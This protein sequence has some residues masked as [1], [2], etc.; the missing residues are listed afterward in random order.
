[1]AAVDEVASELG[2]KSLCAAL[3]VS[4]ASWYR[5]KTPPKMRELQPRPRPARALSEREKDR[6]AD[7]LHEPRFVDRAP[8]EVFATLL[9]EG[10]YLC[11]ER[12]MYRI[13]S[14]RGE[15][16]ERRDQLRHPRDSGRW[17]EERVCWDS[18]GPSRSRA[19][20]RQ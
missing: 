1:M 19:R 13:L 7:T 12:T 8:A 14:E 5:W 3:G 4:R 20:A 6:V 2:V 9:D 16:K 17:R 18:N 15:V 11:S 10:L